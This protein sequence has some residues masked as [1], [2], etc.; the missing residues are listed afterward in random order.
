[1]QRLLIVGY[2]DIARR[3]EQRLAPGTQ[4]RAISRRRGADLDR[5]PTLVPFAGWADTVLHTAPPPADGDTDT[6]TATLLA[7]L[8][9]GNP[10]QRVVYLSTSGVYGDC[11]G[12][13]VDE[14]H[15]LN[16]S[17]ARARR[18]ADAERQL[19]AWCR[20]GGSTLVVLRVPGIYAADRLPLDRLRS[21]VP[22]L[23][24]E[25]DGY[26]NH[27]HADDLAAIAL[28]AC[29]ADA[30]GGIYNASDDSRLKTGAWLDLVADRHGLPRPAR[31]A[32]AAAPGR[33]PAGM[34]SF[35]SE[36]RRLV[37]ERMKREL[38][39]ALR[40]PTVH[41]GVPIAQEAA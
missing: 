11:G 25:D 5:P 31:I 6:R 38:G 9:K 24:D 41:A 21:G 4:V 18:R 33:I 8:G 15:P 14:A 1:M 7:V 34:L 10:P 40:Y 29:A 3:V 19:G 30:P 13:L 22:A 28:R 26:T 2:G 12:A 32:R 35:M 37:N 17:T 23:Q 36:S 39:V 20:T 16:P 27:I